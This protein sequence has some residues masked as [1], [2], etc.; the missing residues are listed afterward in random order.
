MSL[1]AV[2]SAGDV[3]LP[4]GYRNW[5]HVNAMLVDKASPLFD[6]LGGMHS[7]HVNSAGATAL[8]KGGPYPL[9]PSETVNS[10]TSSTKTLLEDSGSHDERE[11]EV[12]RHGRLGLASLG[13]SDPSKPL[14]TMP[15]SNASNVTRRGR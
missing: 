7:V 14:V 15:P 13:R 2:E 5:F 12:R 3:K 10:C 6:V 11:S 4:G 1:S 8:K 9:E